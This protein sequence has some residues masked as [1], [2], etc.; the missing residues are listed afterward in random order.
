MSA[1]TKRGDIPGGADISRRVKTRIQLVGTA[2]LNSAGDLLREFVKMHV[3]ILYNL[4]E[5]HFEI[6][7]SN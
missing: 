4:I 1:L 6:R 3:E 2:L 7:F 5:K